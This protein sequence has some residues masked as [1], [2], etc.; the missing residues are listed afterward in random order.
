MVADIHTLAANMRE[1]DRLEVMASHGP[2]LEEGVRQSLQVS[3]HMWAVDI[4]G[5]LAILGGIAVHNLLEGIASPWL[6]GTKTLE[7]HPGVLI[8]EGGYYLNV[9]KSLYP[10]LFN[11][12]DARNTKAQRWLRRVGFKF[13]Q[14]PVPFGVLQLPFYRFEMRN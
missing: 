12:V 13:D 10:Y 3:S 2:D 1:A 9:A 5:Q 6:L 7:Q 8:R 11:Y 14:E 4:D